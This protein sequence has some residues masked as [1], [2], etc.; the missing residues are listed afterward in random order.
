MITETNKIYVEAPVVTIDKSNGSDE[1]LVVHTY[2]N[3]NRGKMF[4]NKD[5]AAL[6]LIELYKF[7]KN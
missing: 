6:L 4:L 5:E 2:I 1:I 3:H 7:I